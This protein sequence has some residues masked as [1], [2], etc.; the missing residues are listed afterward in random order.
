MALLHKF[1][2]LVLLSAHCLASESDSESDIEENAQTIFQR[3]A[4]GESTMNLLTAWRDVN[5]GDPTLESYL[6]VALTKEGIEGQTRALT[7]ATWILKKGEMEF[8]LG[9]YSFDFGDY[10][11]EALRILIE[12]LKGFTPEDHS[13]KETFEAFKKRADENPKLEKK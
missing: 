1:I 9:S 2:F 3:V 11:E 7:V 5:S 6:V 8:F 13:L 12:R 10:T 4:N